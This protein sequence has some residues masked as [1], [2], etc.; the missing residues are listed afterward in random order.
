M[1]VLVVGFGVI[2]V[3]GIGGS[4]PS[5]EHL[6]ATE[7]SV[8]EVTHHLTQVSTTTPSVK[9]TMTLPTQ[10]QAPSHT[11]PAPT[12]TVETIVLPETVMLNGIQQEYQIAENSAP[13]TL[14]MTLSYWKWSGDQHDTAAFLKPNSR[15]KNVM[16]YEMVFFVSEETELGALWRVGG[17]VELLKRLI[18]ADFPVL[19]EKGVE[20]IGF[21]GW[22]GHYEIIIG[23]NDAE[24]Y[25]MV[26][27][28]FIGKNIIFYEDIHQYWQHFNYTY[29]V[30]YYPA[31]EAE[32]LAILGPHVDE[33]YNYQNAAQIASEEIF[34]KEG[35][36]EAF[37]WFNRGTNL[38]YL[39][40]YAGAAAAYDEYFALYA[41]LNPEETNIPW[42]MIWYQTG[43]YWAYF[44]SGR[45]HDVLNLATYTINA[46]SDPALEETWYW[47]ALAKEALG[48]IDG[49]LADLRE[50]VKL[51]ENFDIGWYQLERIQGGD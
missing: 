5:T 29:I 30:I 17:D 12:P 26:Q 48:D 16:P 8:S 23:Y 41:G 35:R 40:D 42:R 46:A 10:M 11:L 1:G 4:P 44:Y 34:A 24:Q 21:E 37:A 36:E 33:T 22:M 47:R 2:F 51:N 6:L 50:A 15:D 25:F 3:Y 32:V 18:A 45:F 9:P 49:A 38:V 28:S 7:I 20:G 43:P 31:R 13:A 27:D 14:S 39:D 19:I